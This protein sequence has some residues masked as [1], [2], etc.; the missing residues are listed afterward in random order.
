MEL[1]IFIIFKELYN[2]MEYIYQEKTSVNNIVSKLLGTIL[3][4]A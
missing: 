1:P 2:A 3:S 4:I